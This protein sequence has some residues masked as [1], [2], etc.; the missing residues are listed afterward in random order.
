M[1]R[2]CNPKYKP[3]TGHRARLKWAK[4]MRERKRGSWHYL[5]EEQ[6]ERCSRNEGQVRK[7]NKKWEKRE[8]KE[9]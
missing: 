5:V 8:T 4:S 7:R 3:V 6:S 9:C 1:G 2:T